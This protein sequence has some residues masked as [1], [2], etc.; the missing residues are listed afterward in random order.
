MVCLWYTIF[1]IALASICIKQVHFPHTLDILAQSYELK[2]MVR[3]ASHHFTKAIN[4]HIEWICIDDLCVSVR[5]FTPVWF[6]A[7]FKKYFHETNAMKPC[8]VEHNLGC[9][10]RLF[11]NQANT[12]PLRIKY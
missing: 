4:N 6:F 7:V 2:G 3:C 9:L 12:T 10:K 11:F 1:T 5:S 8:R